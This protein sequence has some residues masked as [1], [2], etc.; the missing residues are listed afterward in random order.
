MVEV[1]AANPTFDVT[2]VFYLSPMKLIGTGFHYCSTSIS[3]H[4]EMREGAC[5]LVLTSH[6]AWAFFPLVLLL[7]EDMQRPS[8]T[9]LRLHVGPIF[10]WVHSSVAAGGI[11]FGQTWHQHLENISICK[12]KVDLS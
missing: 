2:E 9:H 12:G 4:Y 5:W 10:G 11:W 7:D 3:V 8:V 1:R 6:S